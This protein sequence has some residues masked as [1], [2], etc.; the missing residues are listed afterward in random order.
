VTTVFLAGDVVTGRGV[1]QILPHPGDPRLWEPV[2]RDARAYVELAEAVN[3]PIPRPVDCSWPWG[4]ALA[5]LNDAAPDARV[6]NLETSI[7]HSATIDTRKRVHYRMTPENIGCLTA[8][9][10]DVCSVANNHVLDFGRCGLRDTLDALAV[11]RIKAAGAGHDAHEAGSPAIVPVGTGSVVVFS[12]A[13]TSSGVPRDWAATGTR[14]GVA[15]LPDLSPATADAVAARVRQVKRP[16]D[17]VIV[18]VHW[19]ANWGYHVPADQVRFAHRLLD[20]GVDVL[21]GHSSHHPRRI[22]VHHG[23]LVLYGCGD[24]INDYEGIRGFDRYRADLRLL[25][26]ASVDP[27]TGEL[28]ALRMTPLRARRMRL[29]HASRE[30]AEHLWGVLGSRVHL[31]AGNELH[32]QL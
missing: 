20:A 4:D 17:V 13:D 16:G 10:P 5:V 7:T 27:G 23:K 3:G 18:S 12:F 15:L 19:G 26:F 14:P 29:Q 21:H 22:E 32:L 25:Y 2:M 6:I 1:D 30:D 9:Q 8:A 24:L 31:V 11:A 28:T